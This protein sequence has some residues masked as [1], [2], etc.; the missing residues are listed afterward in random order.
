MF[1]VGNDDE[2]HVFGSALNP[3]TLH[4]G[5]DKKEIAKPGVK[6]EVKTNNRNKEGG[7]ILSEEQKQELEVKAKNDGRDIWTEEEI[8]VAAEERP[9]DRP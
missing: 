9:D 3:S 6:V 1:D 5:K 7:A 4:G 2:G 8:D